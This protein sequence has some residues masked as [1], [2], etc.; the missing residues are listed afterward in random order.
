M[1]RTV[2]MTALVLGA[3]S[4]AFWSDVMAGERNAQEQSAQP[5]ATAARAGEQ[6][7][8][9]LAEHLKIAQEDIVVTQVEPRTWSN[10]SM[11]CGQPGTVSLTVMTEGYAVLLSAQG[12]EHRVHVSGTNAI[13][14][15]KGMALRRDPRRSANAR[16]LDAMMEKARQDLAQRL[17]VEPA[18]IR[19]AGM[20]PQRWSNSG[21]DC[22]RDGESVQEGP[23]EGFQLS[24]KHAS[25][26][27]TYHTD[28]KEVRPCPAI[29]A[30]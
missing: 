1:F 29:E 27:Y 5:D 16:G 19:L 6:A 30:Q 17:N 25:R 15:D 11:G 7:R 21:L 4:P 22:P 13:V 14:C 26:I 18:T 8:Q 24:L 28:R 2:A 20:R 12:R 3:A 23:V 10:S 9:T